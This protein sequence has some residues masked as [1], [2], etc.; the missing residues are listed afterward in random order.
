MYNSCQ[1]RNSSEMNS[2]ELE[3]AFI[4]FIENAHT[5]EEDNT[6]RLKHY[7][8]GTNEWGIPIKRPE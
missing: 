5:V 2:H 6:I 8:E 3:A 4:K 1:E 7:I